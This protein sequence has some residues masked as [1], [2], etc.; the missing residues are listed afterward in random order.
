MVGFVGDCALAAIALDPGRATD[1]WTHCEQTT[2]LSRSPQAPFVVVA[3]TGSG[4]TF[5]GE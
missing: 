1:L 4:S 2:S 3:C 5:P